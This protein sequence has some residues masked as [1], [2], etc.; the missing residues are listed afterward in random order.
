L[1]RHLVET[2]EEL[3]IPY[4]IRQ[5]GGGGTDAGAIHRQRMGIP[6]ASISIPGRY[7]HTAASIIR[8]EDWKNT[9]ALINAA[10]SRLSPSII[11]TDR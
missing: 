8:L 9:L 1:I 6:T 10:L 7:L 5:P 3:K 4:Q 11:E 2:A